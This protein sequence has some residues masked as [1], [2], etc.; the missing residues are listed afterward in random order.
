[1]AALGKDGGACRIVMIS[2]VDEKNIHDFKALCG[3]SNVYCARIGCAFD[4]YGQGFCGNDFWIQTSYGLAVSLIMKC[5]G[6]A[7]VLLTEKSDE[8]E[9]A[10]FIR[11]IG[12]KTLSS[13]RPF[14]DEYIYNESVVMKLQKL[15]S[16]DCPFKITDCPELNSVYDLL[17]CCEVLAVPDREDFILD[18]SHKLRHGTAF[19]RAAED[20]SGNLLSC[21]MTVGMNHSCAV[22][23]AVAVR[24]DMRRQGLGSA[25]VLSLAELLKEK[26]IYIIR[27]KGKNSE[28]YKSLGFEDSG[29]F[30]SGHCRG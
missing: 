10:E 19:I 28:F 6:D 4:S 23:G 13:S 20:D 15:K 9:L 27:E 22:I 12:C 11:I 14:S 3:L 1:M 30:V 17:C 16:I 24:P 25:A 7:T 2:Y 5:A 29:I 18:M 8:D 21:A 26:D